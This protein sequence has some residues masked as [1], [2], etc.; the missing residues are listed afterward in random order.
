MEN[1]DLFNL[2]KEQDK[3]IN[4]LFGDELEEDLEDVSIVTTKINVKDEV[5]TIALLGPSRMD[6]QKVIGAMEYLADQIDMLF[7]SYKEDKDE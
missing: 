6:Y 7:N 2:V 5:K 4:I 1:D 3:K